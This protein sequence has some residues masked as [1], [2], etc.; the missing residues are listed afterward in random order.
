VRVEFS[1]GF[2]FVPATLRGLRQFGVPPRGPL[3]REAAAMVSAQ[4]GLTSADEVR[5]VLSTGLETIRFFEDA[6]CCYA[7]LGHRVEVGE[8]LVPQMG[9][10]F[11]VREGDVIRFAPIS[12]GVP[13]Y[14]GVQRN[15]VFDRPAQRFGELS[16]SSVMRVL[17]SPDGPSQE[18]LFDQAF[19][20]TTAR[21]RRGVRL[22]GHCD[23]ARPEY[24]SRPVVPG[25][26]QV[27]S[28]DSLIVIGPD[29]PTI[30]GYPIW[31]TVCDADLDKFFRLK[32]G[33]RI[34]FSSS[35]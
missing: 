19:V 12:P 5:E 9:S 24:P 1:A 15:E 31:G 8:N 26:I 6:W 3:D 16:T 22:A 25:V 14:V 30:K 18:K 17:P 13:T 34:R 11:L 32:S 20:V 4:L 2:R 21:D 10:R 27:P 29:G 28:E 23:L 7:G 33:S 35:D